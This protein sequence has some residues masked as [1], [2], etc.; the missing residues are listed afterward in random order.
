MT[1]ASGQLQEW[2]ARDEKTIR[3]DA[4]ARS[5]ATIS[6]KATEHLAPYLS[7][8]PWNPKDA[9]FIG[10]PIDVVFDGLEE[11]RPVRVVFVE[12]KAGSGTLIK[13]ERQIRDAVTNGRVDW[14]EIRIELTAT[15]ADPPISTPTSKPITLEIPKAVRQTPSEMPRPTQAKPSDAPKV[16]VKCLNMS[17]GRSWLVPH[18][19]GPRV[20]AC[21]VCGGL[22]IER[23]KIG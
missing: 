23:T 12:A 19:V 8:F 18:H 3:D 21:P 14:R 15:A 20:E 17:C 6:G 7:Q 10:S 5:Q 16:Q 11:K 13:R 9:R 2:K 4:I 22:M 1:W